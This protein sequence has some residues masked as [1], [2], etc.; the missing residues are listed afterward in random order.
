MLQSCLWEVLGS[1]LGQ[2]YQLSWLRF[3]CGFSHL[4]CINPRRVL[5]IR[6]L[7]FLPNGSNSSVTTP[8]DGT[9]YTYWQHHKINKKLKYNLIMYIIITHADITY[10]SNIRNT[11]GS[12]SSILTHCISARG[13]KNMAS[14]TGLQDA[15]INLWA[16]NTYNINT[17]Q[18]M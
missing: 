14:N 4:L 9:Q 2:D 5:Q 12:I 11:S 15:K 13:P 3:L 1:N 16:L 18:F 6:P 7:L 17:I 10:S 8:V